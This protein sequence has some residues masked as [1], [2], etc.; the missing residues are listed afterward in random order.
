[1]KEKNVL[2]LVENFRIFKLIP[3]IMLFA[4]ILTGLMATQASA[5]EIITKEDIIEKVVAG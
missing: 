3:L 4:L 2:N 5:F 1:M